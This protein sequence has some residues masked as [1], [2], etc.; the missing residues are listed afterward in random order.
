MAEEDLGSVKVVLLDIGKV[1]LST[2]NFSNNPDDHAAFSR[3]RHR[4]KKHASFRDGPFP[5][6]PAFLFPVEVLFLGEPKERSTSSR[7]IRL[8]MI[9]FSLSR[10]S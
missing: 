1:F 3:R 4:K 10:F 5:S 6:A 7:E 9:C 2:A 8:H